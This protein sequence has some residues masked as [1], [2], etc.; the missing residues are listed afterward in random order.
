MN[1]FVIFLVF[2]VEIRRCKLHEQTNLNN[3]IIVSYRLSLINSIKHYSTTQL[4]KCI[5]RTSLPF[6]VCVVL[7]VCLKEEV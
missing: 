3:T 1:V 4:Y 6:D 2:F 5:D 7:R